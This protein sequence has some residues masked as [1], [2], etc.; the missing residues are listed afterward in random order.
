MVRLNSV[1][2]TLWPGPLSE[3][4]GLLVK[5]HCVRPQTVWVMF[6]CRPLLFDRKSIILLFWFV[7]LIR[8]SALLIPVGIVV[9]WE[10]NLCGCTA[11]PHVMAL[12]LISLQLR[13]T[14]VVPRP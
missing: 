1:A 2:I 3:V 12:L 6:I 4:A 10:N 5:T 11:M 7:S 9:W 8:C 14:N 13:Q